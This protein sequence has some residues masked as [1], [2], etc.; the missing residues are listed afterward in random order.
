MT[1]KNEPE[2]WNESSEN[3]YSKSADN[4]SNNKVDDVNNKNVQNIFYNKWRNDCCIEKKSNITI[5]N[6]LNYIKTYFKSY[7]TSLFQ[8]VD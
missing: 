8:N 6:S 1:A 7:K 5:S 4:I 2:I 3:N